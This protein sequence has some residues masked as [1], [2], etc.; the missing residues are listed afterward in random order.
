MTNGILDRPFFAIPYSSIRRT[1][2][3]PTKI[4]K[5]KYTESY[6]AYTSRYIDFCCLKLHFQY[7]SLKM[8]FSIK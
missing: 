5:K 4:R 2:T 7:K 3:L 8:V 1:K 6:R